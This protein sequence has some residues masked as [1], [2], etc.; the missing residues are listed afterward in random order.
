MKTTYITVA[1]F[2]ENGGELEEGRQIFDGEDAEN[3][4]FGAFVWD[5]NT[6]LTNAGKT[7]L[8]VKVECTI[9]YK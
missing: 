3:Y 1:E 6:S 2:L 5:D 9:I 7:S 8:Y 4:Y